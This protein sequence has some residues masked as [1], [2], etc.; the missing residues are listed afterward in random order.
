MLHLFIDS[1]IYLKF[2]AYSDDTLAE[3][4]K[5]QALVNENHITLH[6]TGQV[7][8]EIERNRESKIVEALSR[9]Q[10]SVS[11]PEIPRFAMHFDEASELVKRSK[12]AADAKSKLSEKIQAEIS[13]SSLRADEL[14]EQLISVANQID[15]DDEIIGLA[16]IRR[17]VGNPPG[18]NDS[19][20]DQLNWEAL[21]KNIEDETDLHIVTVDSDFLSKL[22][23]TQPSSFI[24]KEW[25]EKKSGDLKTY[26]SLGSFAKEH[27]PAISLPSDVVKSAAI[28]KLVKSSNFAR[29]HSQIEILEEVFDDIN[30]EDAI[31]IF[32]GF[33]DNSQIN[34]IYND[35]DVKSFMTKLHDKFADEISDELDEELMQKA[36]YLGVPF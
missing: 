31:T 36:S 23:K 22:S 1:N 16:Q 21:I 12:E 27:F 35:E 28:N 8:D 24:Q 19:L 30:F 18:K 10:K 2:Y 20:G 14:I 34:W 9:F 17:L 32:N 6:I 4:E 26:S 3:L 13:E 7:I 25:S 29:T 33:L 11:A 5:L 15:F